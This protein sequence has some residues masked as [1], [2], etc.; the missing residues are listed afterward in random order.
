LHRRIAD[1]SPNAPLRS[2]YL[3]LSEGLE[4]MLDDSVIDEFDAPAS[5]A[6]HRE[7]VAAIG[8][9]LGARLESAISAH[10]PLPPPGL[11]TSR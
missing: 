5:I 4:S 1:L 11:Q 6:I 8:D 3:T 2:I 9:G 10:T 7:L